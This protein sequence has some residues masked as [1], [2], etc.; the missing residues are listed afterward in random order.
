MCGMGPD[1]V[2]SRFSAGDQKRKTRSLHKPDEF[3]FGFCFETHNNP[4]H[5]DTDGGE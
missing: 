5:D 3:L 1:V 2:L 4:I